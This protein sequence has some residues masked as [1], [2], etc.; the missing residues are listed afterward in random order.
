MNVLSLKVRFNRTEHMR[1]SFY[2]LISGRM[3]KS[4]VLGQRLVESDLGTELGLCALPFPQ[5]F[6]KFSALSPEPLITLHPWLLPTQT[7]PRP[8]W[9]GHSLTP[10]ASLPCPLF[11]GAAIHDTPE[12]LVSEEST[13]RTSFLCVL[14][15]Y[16]K[17]VLCVTLRLVCCILT[18]LWI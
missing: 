10:H 7:G 18:W 8:A 12:A 1:S 9:R 11:P 16:S 13:L 6:L 2:L 15:L 17:R 4:R 3:L 14:G 5:A